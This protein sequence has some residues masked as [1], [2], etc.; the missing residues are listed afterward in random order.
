[1]S[2]IRSTNTKPEITLRKTLW[3]NGLRGYRLHLKKLPGK[4]DIVFSKSK[5][6]IFVDGCFWHKCPVCYTEPETNKEYWIP[7]INQNVLKDQEQTRDLEKMGYTVIRIWEHEV[8]K[9]IE[10]VINRIIAILYAEN[11]IEGD[12][13]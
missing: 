3:K 11:Q 8:E 6:V 9:S 2:K 12:M 4:P 5:V 1:M 7:K 13:T 10:T